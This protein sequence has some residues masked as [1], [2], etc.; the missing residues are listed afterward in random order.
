[1]ILLADVGGTNA[2]LAL[3][4]ADGLR[5]GTIARFAG[6]DHAGFD[7]VLQLYLRRQ[8]APAISAACVAFAG[9]VGDDSAR[10]TNRDW[11]ISRDWLI[12][13]TGAKRV[14]LINDMMALGH[15]VPGLTGGSISLL[16]AGNAHRDNRQALVVNVGTGFNTCPLRVFHDGRIACLEAEEGH[17]SLPVSVA[18]LLQARLDGGSRPSGRGFATVEDLFSGQGLARFHVALTGRRLGPEEVTAAAGER[19]AQVTMQY[20]V[21]LF[22]VMG[23]ELALRHLPFGRSFGGIYLAGGVGRACAD[24]AAD[25]TAGF[26]RDPLM[27]DIPLAVSVR[28]IRDDMAGLYGCLAALG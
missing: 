26:L 15:A 17:A 10:L 18:K 4:D 21:E 3:A 28:V 27:R 20:F 5:V 19:V 14:L 8:G 22:G 9:P 2:R 16:R 1:M 24:H 13:L 12:R 23:R 25:F 6:S 11:F 7:E